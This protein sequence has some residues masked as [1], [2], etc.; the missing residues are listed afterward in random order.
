MQSYMMKKMKLIIYSNC[1]ESLVS[2]LLATFIF[3]I[4]IVAFLNFSYTQQI[5]SK[6]IQALST[7]SNLITL[8]M[9][10]LNDPDAIVKTLSSA[11]NSS[12]NNCITGVTCYSGWWIYE[13]SLYDKN[14]NALTGTT[15]NPVR[16]DL[17]GNIC[18]TASSSCIFEASSSFKVYCTSGF[19]CANGYI[20][21]SV[22]LSQ[23]KNFAPA[24]NLYLK[25][26]EIKDIPILNTSFIADKGNFVIGLYTD[27]SPI[28][29]T[30]NK[31]S[32]P[33][34]QSA[35]PCAVNHFW[36]M[37]PTFDSWVESSGLGAFSGEGTFL[38]TQPTCCRFAYTWSG[39][40]PRA[41][42]QCD[43]LK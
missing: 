16:Y 43:F 4:I 27:G 3:G 40:L 28:F 7:R 24:M 21:L 6:Q 32:N 23:N 38:L 42:L 14:S 30:M 20:F 2:S 41:E 26:I 29:S 17:N 1:G 10:N 12:L 22:K 36:G 13:Y 9:Q 25:D 34:L 37:S 5:A 35:A 39:T 31:F 19:S 11:S 18:T 8:F 33:I 15:T